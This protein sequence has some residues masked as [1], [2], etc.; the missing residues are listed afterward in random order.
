MN[1]GERFSQIYL[2]RGKPTRD[3]GRFRNRIAACFR[4]QFSRNYNDQVINEYEL[5]TGARCKWRGIARWFS[6]DLQEA[7]L[8]DLLD[9]ITIVYRVLCKNRLATHGQEWRDFVARA[10]QEENIGYRV[11]QNCVV[12]YFVDEQFERIRSATVKALE[13]PGFAG[14]LGAF[15]DAHRHLDSTPPDTKAA[16]RS[17]FESLEVLARL[18]VPDTQ[19]LNRW[20]VQNTLKQ[21]CLAVANHDPIEQKVLSGLFDGLADWVESLHNYRHGQPQEHVVAPSEELAVLALSSGAA[22]LRQIAVYAARIRT[23]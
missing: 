6:E 14:V 3:S 9:G 13:A 21:K 18:I 12:H 22:Y 17:M 19:N 16:V 7:E 20:L 15:E 2:E 11:D 1:Q 8:R 4:D 5:E 23:D 10:M